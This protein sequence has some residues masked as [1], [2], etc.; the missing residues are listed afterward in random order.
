MWYF[1]GGVGI[2]IAIVVLIIVLA[3]IADWIKKVDDA[4]ECQK[5]FVHHHEI[6]FLDRKFTARYET[7]SLDSEMHRR[8]RDLESRVQM[9]EM[10]RIDDMAKNKKKPSQSKPT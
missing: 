10:A 4:M 3:S 9:I 5:Y 1:M 6:E 2:G 7:A 8:H